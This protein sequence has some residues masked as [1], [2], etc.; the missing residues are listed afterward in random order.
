MLNTNLITSSKRLSNAKSGPTKNY[1]NEIKK[2]KNSLFSNSIIG[3]KSSSESLGR[4]C[5]V[6]GSLEQEVIWAVNIIKF[7]ENEINEFISK[8]IFFETLVI[9]K[10]YDSAIEYLDL[11]ENEHG[12]SLWLIEAK[13]ALLQIK[14]GL[15]AQKNFIADLYN[16]RKSAEGFDIVFYLSFLISQRNEP[17][18]R[19]DS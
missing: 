18:L 1:P 9:D 12:F 3:K 7:H 19:A 17:L 6:K 8:R 2:I 5:S 14:D 15:D 13:I 4:Y 11:I 16:K 10:N